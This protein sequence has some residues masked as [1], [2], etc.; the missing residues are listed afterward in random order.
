MPTKNSF[1]HHI[2]LKTNNMNNLN[3]NYNRIE[4]LKRLEFIK[5]TFQSFENKKLNVLDVGCGNGNISRYI[6]SFG[7]KVLGIDISKSS[8]DKANS[9][10]SL[11][12]VT[13]KNI[14]AEQIDPEMKYDLIICSEVIEHLHIPNLV[15]NTLRNKLTKDGVL[16]ITVPNGYGPRE[17]LITKPVQFIMEYLP[18]TFKVLNAVKSSLGFK[19]T[20]VQSDA[21]DL[22]HI[23]FFSKKSL[24]NMATS[25]NLKLTNFRSSNFIESVF[26]F[27]LIT[28]KSRMLQKLDCWVADQI[29]HQFASGF[30]SAWKLK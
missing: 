19:G 29:P 26:P 14:P 16:I 20:T 6:G 22:K 2:Q 28:K 27:S 21:E 12:N 10:N 8:I 13:F 17:V 3:I 7:H 9:L 25:N 15:V 5:N 30:M 18:G 1:T 4:D 11:D 23:Q 24:L